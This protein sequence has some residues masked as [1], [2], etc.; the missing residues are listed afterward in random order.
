MGLRTSPKND[1]LIVSLSMAGTALDV[2]LSMLIVMNYYHSPIEVVVLRLAANA[3]THVGIDA[4]EASINRFR[5][6]RP[7]AAA[8]LAV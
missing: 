3:V 2:G 4:L 6:F 8:T 5:G 1:G 7:P